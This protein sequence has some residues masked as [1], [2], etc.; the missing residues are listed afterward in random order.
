MIWKYLPQMTNGLEDKKYYTASF[1]DLFCI[2]IWGDEQSRKIEAVWEAEANGEVQESA[3]MKN[4]LELRVFSCEEEVR[5]WREDVGERFRVRTLKDC[6]EKGI[7]CM[8]DEPGEPMDFFCEVQLLDIDR[9]RS[10]DSA[11]VRTTGGGTYS[12]PKEIFCMVNPGLIVRHYFGRYK[13][14]GIACVKDWRCVGFC[15]LKEDE[16]S[17]DMN[18]EDVN[19]G[20][21]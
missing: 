11:N 15:D 5:L 2:G 7:A 16:E 14:T 19:C 10:G 6:E 21:E 9:A 18:R 3:W 20:K 1:T 17:G 12:L 4:L 8:D 13:E